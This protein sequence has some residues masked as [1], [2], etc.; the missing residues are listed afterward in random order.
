M[1]DTI[2]QRPI[3]IVG[4][5]SIGRRHLRNLRACGWTNIVLHRTG[6][7]TLPDLDAEIAGIPTYDSLDEALAQAP[8]AAVIANPTAL[9]MPTAIQAAR[10]ACH[11]LIEKPI[12]HT[13][14]GIHELVRAVEQHNVQ[15]LVGFQ[16]RYHP[17]LNAIK[18]HWIDSGLIG[19]VL[20]V[21]CMWSEY[22]PDWHTWEDYRTSYAAR[23]DLGGGVTLTLCHPFDYLRW[24]IGEVVEVKGM[25]GTLSDLGIDADDTADALLRFGGANGAQ[26][27]V[28]LDYVGMPNRHEFR[29]TAQ[30]GVIIWNSDDGT[31][32][33][34][35]NDVRLSRAISPP[36][37]FERNDLF[38]A[39]TRH[40]LDVIAG[41]A[42]PCCTLH[43]GVRALEIALAVRAG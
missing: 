35:H 38:M 3:L 32:S 36:Q 14:D 29:I 18:Q 12:S 6:S 17:V 41:N 10:A 2:T 20:H 37:G 5:G 33:L 28:H 23:A 25:I 26:G 34:L 22:L 30:H 19:R 24:L 11:L 42:L 13:L 8:I 1:T 7:S 27:H 31:A 9:H 43:D 4:M 15:A 21:E 16:F 39:Q 40:F